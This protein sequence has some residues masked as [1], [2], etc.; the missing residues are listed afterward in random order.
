MSESDITS[1]GAQDVRVLNRGGLTLG[2]FSNIDC[3]NVEVNRK[4]LRLVAIDSFF[5]II[6]ISTR[7]KD[8][9]DSFLKLLTHP[10]IRTSKTERILEK[11]QNGYSIGEG[12][13]ARL[14]IDCRV[15]TDFCRV[16]LQLREIGKIKGQ[17]LKYAQNCERFMVGLADTGLAALIDE[18]T[19][20][21]KRKKDEYRQLFLS[22]IREEHSD[23]VKEFPDTFFDGIY[24]VYH[25]GRSGRN[26]P[27]FFGAFIAKYVYYPLANSH[28]A[29]L[30]KLREKDPV[31][32]VHGRQYKLH[33][34]LTR[35][36]GKPALKRHLDQVETILMLSP[37]KGAF[38]RNFKKVFPQPYDQL[39]LDFGDDV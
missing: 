38:K 25:V 26:H 33:Q 27:S 21:R 11:V 31:V 19:G 18:A 20:Y 32:S 23:W 14:F 12:V 1:Q 13:A 39:E 6:G 3:A 7:A 36:V 2:V 10:S 15:I 17:Y 4:V 5:G 22:F 30:E 35:E 37:D 9:V 28:G 16:M 8:S 29:I 24:K 34:F